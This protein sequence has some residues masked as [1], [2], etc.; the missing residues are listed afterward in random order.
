YHGHNLYQENVAVPLV[1]AAP[2][3]PPRRLAGGPV[4]L[5]DVAPTLLNLAGL[6]IPEAM[7]G[8]DLTAALYGGELDSGRAVFLESHFTG[9]YVSLAYQAAVIVGSDKLIEDTAT[10]TFEL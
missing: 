5:I 9:Y 10:R 2:G 6:E 8:H 4:S 7:R 1:I 3:A